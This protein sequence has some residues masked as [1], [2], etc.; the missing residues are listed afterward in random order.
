M[1][2]KKNL[3]FSL[4]GLVFLLT[5][6]CRDSKKVDVQSPAINSEEFSTDLPD[7]EYLIDSSSGVKT[8]GLVKANKLKKFR[9]ITF[10]GKLSKIGY[11]NLKFNNQALVDDGGLPTPEELCIKGGCS[12]VCAIPIST[13]ATTEYCSC[14]CLPPSSTQGAWMMNPEMLGP[15]FKD[16]KI[17]GLSVKLTLEL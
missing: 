14:L 16:T 9:A 5:S 17:S 11:I 15:S 8:Y 1:N 3:F 10:D 2:S 7:G 6:S 4:C 13:A 12:W